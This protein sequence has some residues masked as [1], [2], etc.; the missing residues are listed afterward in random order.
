MAGPEPAV[1][2]APLSSIV[3]DPAGEATVPSAS[4]YVVAAY[5][6]R[7]ESIVVGSLGAVC[8]QRGWH[9]Y[10]G[11]ARRG[12]AAPVARHR[13]ADKPLRWHADYLFSRHAA[14]LAW[15]FDVAP[16]HHA[17]SEGPEQQTHPAA[18]AKLTQPEELAHR[19]EPERPAECLLAA[20][21]LEG[22]PRARRGPSRFGASD[23]A[24][25]GHLL[26]FPDRAALVRAV[27]GPGQATAI[28][29]VRGSGEPAVGPANTFVGI[30]AGGRREE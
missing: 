17:R 16:A 4:L 9:A 30:L 13:R 21:L 28:P 5:V 24:C 7:R 19:S 1:P 29:Y 10:V 20:A 18:P 14:T 27:A 26:W 22:E 2:V 15:T 8:F 25:P 6:P 3:R 11:S 12:R 23:C